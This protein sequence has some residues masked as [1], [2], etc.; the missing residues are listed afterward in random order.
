M[1]IAAL[2]SVTVALCSFKHADRLPRLAER[3]RAQASPVSFEISA[4][5]N[6]S[7]DKALDLVTLLQ[8]DP[9][10]SLKFVSE[11][12]LGIDVARNRALREAEGSRFMVFLDVDEL[13]LP[14]PLHAAHNTLER[15]A[16]DCAGGQAEVEFSGTTRSPWLSGVLLGFLGAV[17]HEP[18][19]T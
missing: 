3:L 8:A 10:P 6:I 19:A 1:S 14:G 15:E 17:D 7:P 4:V 11:E 13:A 5:N 9:G 16:A 2:P 18:A 12:S